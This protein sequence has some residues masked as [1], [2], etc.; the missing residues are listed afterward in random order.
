MLGYTDLTALRCQLVT[1]SAEQETFLLIIRSR[2]RTVT[3]ASNHPSRRRGMTGVPAHHHG[4]L[5]AEV[6]L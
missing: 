2:N 3:E 6:T 1:C 4:R 5:V